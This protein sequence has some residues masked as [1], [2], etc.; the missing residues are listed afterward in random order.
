MCQSPA[1]LVVTVIWKRL[2]R[3]FEAPHTVAASLSS[4]LLAMLA[5]S[6]LLLALI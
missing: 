5:I 1:A 2:A 3:L 4:S 6:A